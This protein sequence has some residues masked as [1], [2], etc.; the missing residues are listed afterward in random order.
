MR[1]SNYNKQAILFRIPVK[2]RQSW[3]GPLKENQNT[4]PKRKA[5]VVKL[6][7]A[8]VKKCYTEAE[9]NQ[10]KYCFLKPT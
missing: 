1:N 8:L 7:N 4:L 2:L 5:V 9:N 10:D 6:V 3:W